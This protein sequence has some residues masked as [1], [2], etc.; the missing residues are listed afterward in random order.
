MSIISSYMRTDHRHCDESFSALENIVQGGDAEAIGQAL[1][2]FKKDFLTHFAMEEEVMFP[3]IEAKT[4]MTM[5]P[6]QVMRMEHEQMRHLI[7][8]MEDALSRG[9]TEQFL[10]LSETF[11]ILVQQHNMKEEQILYTMAD[12]VLMAEGESVLER[13][14]AL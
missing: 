14:K 3:E 11:M 2:V 7:V 13:M 9:D 12:H 5:G 1:E 4:G 6:T 10:G 8:R